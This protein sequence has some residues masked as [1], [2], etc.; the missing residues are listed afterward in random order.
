MTIKNTGL[1][2]SA[3]ALWSARQLLAAL[4]FKGLVAL[5]VNHKTRQRQV[6]SGRR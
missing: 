4:F 2:P 6:E 5:R 1:T 3:V